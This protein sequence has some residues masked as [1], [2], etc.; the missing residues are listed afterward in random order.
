MS[1]YLWSLKTGDEVKFKHIKF[2]V[3]IQYPFTQ[4]KTISMISGGTGIAPMYQAL[5]SLLNTTGDE[6]K[7]VLLNTNC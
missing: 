5:C 2:N 4:Y 6:T 7:V 1:N 3:K